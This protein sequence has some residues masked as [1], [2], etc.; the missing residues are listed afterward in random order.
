MQRIKELLEELKKLNKEI[1][2]AVPTNSQT[3]ASKCLEIVEHL[4]PLSFVASH[5]KLNSVYR[6]KVD[7]NSEF[8]RTIE[9]NFSEGVVVFR[10]TNALSLKLFSNR[11]SPI[12]ECKG[13]KF[14]LDAYFPEQQ[15]LDF[16]VSYILKNID[17]IKNFYKE[18][19]FYR[20]LAEIEEAK[21]T[22]LSLENCNPKRPL[23]SVEK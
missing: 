22:L 16:G 8:P 2:V 20:L 10:I 9:I 4:Q 3:F 23:S 19:I 18:R 21:E 17:E 12:L 1:E 11:C 5:T 13:I 15:L 14:P 7:K 6:L